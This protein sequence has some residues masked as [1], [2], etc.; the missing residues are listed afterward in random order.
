VIVLQ[1]SGAI[2]L[3]AA[4]VIVPGPAWTG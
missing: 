3:Q 1:A 4:G 2:V